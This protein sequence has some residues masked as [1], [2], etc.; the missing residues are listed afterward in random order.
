[1]LYVIP[2]FRQFKLPFVSGVVLVFGSVPCED[3]VCILSAIDMTCVRS[4][5]YRGVACPVY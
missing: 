3:E 5:D 1:M 4:I 2:M